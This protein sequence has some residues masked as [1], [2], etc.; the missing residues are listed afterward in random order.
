ML[1]GF[2]DF[3]LRGN[4]VD[5]AVAVVIGAAFGAVVTALVK[6]ILTPIIAFLSIAAAVFFFVVKPVNYLQ[7][8]RKKSIAAGEE[9]DPA[10]LSDEA[11]LL[12]EIRDLLRQQRAV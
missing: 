4:V 11:L 3:I 1:K 5:L 7:E 9:P 2:R 6:D 10:S 12:T 8:R